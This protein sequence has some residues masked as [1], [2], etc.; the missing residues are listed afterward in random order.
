ME[1]HIICPC[2]GNKIVVSLDDGKLSVFFNA[3]NQEEL[4][5]VLSQNGIELG[6]MK[7]GEKTNGKYSFLQ[8]KSFT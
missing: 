2:C 8:L 6:T 1:E 3:E 7:G 5:K 4:Q